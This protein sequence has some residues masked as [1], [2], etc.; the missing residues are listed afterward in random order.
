MSS[1]VRDTRDPSSRTGG[2]LKPVYSDR[3]MRCL[4]VTESE[5]KQIGLAN[6]FLT[7]LFGMGSALMAFGVDIM[8]DSLLSE[9]VPEAA[10]T[11][12]DVVQPICFILGAGFWVGAAWV[13]FWRRDMIATIRKESA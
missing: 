6:I 12:V 8:K 3:T 13:W 1:T 4:T 2:T 11:V 7:F 9:S 10:R 5:L